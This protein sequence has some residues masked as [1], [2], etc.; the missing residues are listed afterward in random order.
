MY[1]AKMY[2][3]YM[4]IQIKLKLFRL[5]GSIKLQKMSGN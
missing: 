4:L 3:M 5:Y 2:S 1:D